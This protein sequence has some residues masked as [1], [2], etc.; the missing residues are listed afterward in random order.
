MTTPQKP[1]QQAQKRPSRAGKRYVQEAQ[2]QAHK[3][4]ELWK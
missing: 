3:L 1:K 2:P 4:K